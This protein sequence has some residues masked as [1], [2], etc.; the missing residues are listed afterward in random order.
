[1]GHKSQRVT[2]CTSPFTSYL[3]ADTRSRT[4]GHAQ[5]SPIRNW[6]E[7]SREVMGVDWSNLQKELF[8]SCSWDGSIKLVRDS[9][10]FCGRLLPLLTTRFSVYAACHPQW[11]PNNPAS[12]QTLPAR[13]YLLSPSVLL[14]KMT[15]DANALLI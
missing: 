3:N 2:L 8:A 12:L 4:C 6:H 7:H 5:D 10:C 13:T 11:T 14:F 9:G 1:V 15:A